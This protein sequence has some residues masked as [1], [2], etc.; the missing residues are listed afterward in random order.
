[1]NKPSFSHSRAFIAILQCACVSFFVVACQSNHLSI[2]D[3]QIA[4]DKP[5]LLYTSDAADDLT[6][7]ALG[8]SLFSTQ[9]KKGNVSALRSN[10]S[11]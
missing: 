2:S 11:I 10:V 4:R 8:G 5:C 9:N 1:M 6:R 3:N 7:V